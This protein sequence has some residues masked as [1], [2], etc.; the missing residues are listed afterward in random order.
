MDKIGMI[1]LVREVI[2]E[3]AYVR[4]E[5]GDIHLDLKPTKI[6]VEKL[7]EMMAAGDAETNKTEFLKV[8]HKRLCAEVRALDRELVCERATRDQL[9]AAVQTTHALVTLLQKGYEE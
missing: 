4:T 5:E 9:S 7:I 8:E 2:K 3:S 6:L 1:K